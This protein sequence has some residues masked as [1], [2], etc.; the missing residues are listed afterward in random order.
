MPEIKY[1]IVDTETTGLRV[2]WHEITQIS[3]IRCSDRK[4]LNRYIKAHHPKRVN[5]I[6][7]EKTGRVYSD[8]FKGDGRKEVVEFCNNFFAEDG[9]NPEERCIV[10]HN[11][12]KFD[13]GFLHELWSGEG[14]EFPACLWL[15]T[16]LY[17]GAWKKKKGLTTRKSNL[18][19]SLEA[20]GITP[21]PGGHNAVVD[22]Q[23]NYILW[24][25][26][27][28]EGLPAVPHMKRFAHKLSPEDDD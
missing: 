15:D 7:L 16:M 26:L 27:K 10:G 24:D 21:R 23:N 14:F 1:Y 19:W 8:L 17:I 20:L 18:N 22:T 25:K 2:G 28:K 12:I 6:A 4:Q 5:P 9:A 13:K 11:I 3:I